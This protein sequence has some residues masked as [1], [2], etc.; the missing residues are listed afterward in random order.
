MFKLRVEKNSTQM[1]CMVAMGGKKC[2]TV[3]PA[4]WLLESTYPGCLLKSLLGQ[5]NKL[6]VWRQPNVLRPGSKT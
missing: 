3:Y 1:M 6:L 4:L 2:I 5:H